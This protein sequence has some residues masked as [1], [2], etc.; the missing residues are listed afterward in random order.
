[1]AAAYKI[2]VN[3][4]LPSIKNF[5][6]VSAM[7]DAFA[8]EP[9]SSNATRRISSGMSSGILIIGLEEKNIP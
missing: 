9:D 1:M 4:S 3:I 8:I 7:D 2:V 6:P 5:F